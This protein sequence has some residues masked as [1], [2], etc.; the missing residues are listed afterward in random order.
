LI[1]NLSLHNG[2]IL[3]PKYSLI[4]CVFVKKGWIEKKKTKLKKTGNI[5]DRLQILVKNSFE[6]LFF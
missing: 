1:I 2:A 3:K 6:S 4:T 5:S